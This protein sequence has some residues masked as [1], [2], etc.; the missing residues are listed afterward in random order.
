MQPFAIGG[1][2]LAGYS[3]VSLLVE[4]IGAHQRSSLQEH[5]HIRRSRFRTSP[6]VSMLR[7]QSVSRYGVANSI[8]ATITV[9]RLSHLLED[10]L[11]D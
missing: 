6:P 4:A 5:L 7:A 9:T 11:G 2:F 3:G 10:C 1:P 8:A